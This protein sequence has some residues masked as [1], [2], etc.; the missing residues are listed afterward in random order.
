M[1]SRATLAG[2]ASAGPEERPINAMTAKV[3]LPSLRDPRI[4]QVPL[5]PSKSRQAATDQSIRPSCDRQLVPSLRPQSEARSPTAQHEPLYGNRSASKLRNRRIQE[6]G[7]RTAVSTGPGGN[8]A[9]EVPPP[10]AIRATEPGSPPASPAS[11]CLTRAL[12]T[13][14]VRR[15][16]RALDA[17]PTATLQYRQWLPRVQ[18]L[19]GARS[20]TQTMDGHGLAGRS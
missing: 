17:Q 7:P 13:W 12:S 2:L 20:V 1:P 8:G 19:C 16:K 18:W 5:T 6:L 3:R 15:R 10:R 11:I 9:A 4:R 14:N